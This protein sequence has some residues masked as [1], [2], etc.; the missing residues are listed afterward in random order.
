MGL[1][2]FLPLCLCSN[3]NPSGLWWWTWYRNILGIYAQKPCI[4]GQGNQPIKWIGYG[5]D[6]NHILIEHFKCPRYARAW[7]SRSCLWNREYIVAGLYSISSAILRMET[8]SKLLSTRFGARL[9]K[10]ARAYPAYR[11]LYVLFTPIVQVYE[12]LLNSVQW[13]NFILHR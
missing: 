10:S 6:L 2:T 12:N 3:G 7:K 9:S 13:N 4:Y 11:A 8:S 5:H 1:G